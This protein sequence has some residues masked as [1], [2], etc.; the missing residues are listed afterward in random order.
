[1]AAGFLLLLLVFQM[2]GTWLVFKAQQIAVR[3]EIK[4]RIKA[5]VPKEDRVTV[6]IPK[7][8][9]AQNN[10][11]FQRIHSGEF[12]LDGEMYDNLNVR[13]KGD[14]L[15]YECIHDVKESGL[16]AKLE[17]LTAEEQH[18]NPD[19][20]R[21]RERLFS[22]LAD[23][24]LGGQSATCFLTPVSELERKAFDPALR[25]GSSTPDCPPPEPG[26]S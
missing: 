9:E 14:T 19:N 20:Q 10:E 8:W 25:L 18:E 12:R 5:G 15:Y 6:A 23:D 11:R 17:E 26:F 3:R 2:E 4:Q 16:F 1:M 22:V 13:E 24:F 21:S 7:S